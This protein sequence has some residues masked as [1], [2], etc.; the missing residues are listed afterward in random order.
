MW[1]AGG[2]CDGR[3]SRSVHSLADSAGR[4][5]LLWWQQVGPTGFIAPCHP[6]KTDKLPSGSLWLHG[7][8]LLPTATVEQT[9]RI[10]RYTVVAI[11]QVVDPHLHH[12]NAAVA[13]GESVAGKERGPG[14]N[15]KCPIV[16][17]KIIILDLRR[18]IGHEGPLDARTHQ[19]A[20]GVVVGGGDRCTSRR[21]GDGEVVA[22]DPT[23][24]GLAIKEPV[25][26]GHAEPGSQG[27]DPIIV[28]S[29]DS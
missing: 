24:T 21:I 26:I 5:W 4:E 1:A 18:P 8:L 2:H 22:A 3:R 6:T 23:A 9:G 20:A 12:L 14:R 29:L 10:G 28:G 19:P 16:Q 27:R 25:A 15:G 11:E 13:L 17:P 7:P